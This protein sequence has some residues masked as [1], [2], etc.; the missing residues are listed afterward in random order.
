M[1]TDCTSRVWW[2]LLPLWVLA[3][4]V[5]GPVCAQN[6]TR[7]VEVEG[8]GGSYEAAVQNGIVEALRQVKGV[9]IDSVKES[10][11]R[12]RISGDSAGRESSADV[13]VDDQFD[14]SL[15]EATAGYAHAYEV[16]NKAETEPGDWRVDLRV[17]IS[18]YQTPGLDPHNR[19]AIAVLPFYLAKDLPDLRRLDIKPDDAVRNVMDRCIG[20]LVQSRRFTVLDRQHTE[21]ILREKQLILSADANPEELAKLG[22]ALGADYLLVGVIDDLALTERPQHIVMTGESRLKVEARLNLSYRIVVPA[23]R[24]IKWADSVT[25]ELTQS[26]PDAS[27]GFQHQVYQK[28]VHAAADRIVLGALANIYPIRIVALQPESRIVTL[29]Q[30]GSTLQAG[31]RLDVFE[32]GAVIEDPYTGEALGRD[33]RRVGTVEVVRVLPKI[34][35]ARVT[36]GDMKAWRHR[37]LLCRPCQDASRPGDA[38]PDK[39][40]PGGSRLPF[41]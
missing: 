21:A 17:S 15:W 35:Q 25:V 23:T 29:N 19:R 30:G 27:A 26:A 36:D 28:L 8:F 38:A 2:R 14:Q 5:A 40:A 41:K 37:D 24:Q 11:S 1:K 7:S 13:S 6:I 9:R 20:Q 18:D 22:Q 3:C 39:A 10:V 32:L 16:L 31:T 4:L 34:A 33:E 12:M